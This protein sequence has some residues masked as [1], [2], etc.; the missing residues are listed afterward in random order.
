MG[1]KSL[2]L[3]M[4]Q[5]DMSVSI[6]QS[7]WCGS[8][9]VTWLSSVPSCSPLF[10][11]SCCSA[12]SSLA[13]SSSILFTP[14]SL[15]PCCSILV[16][17]L[18]ESVAVVVVVAGVAVLAGAGM[19][20]VEIAAV[21][22]TC[23]TS[24]TACTDLVSCFTCSALR[25][26]NVFHTPSGNGPNCVLAQSHSIFSTVSISSSVSVDDVAGSVSVGVR[27]VNA[28]SAV[29]FGLTIMCTAIGVALN[30]CLQ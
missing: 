1:W 11:S 16:M 17:A 22:V 15:S 23:H 3:G 26:S 29:A 9:G 7:N 6:A 25:S 10:N 14:G 21:V 19:V 12:F 5:I 18:F 24:F 8:H 2:G 13:S 27:M 30:S 4:G 20:V 28:I